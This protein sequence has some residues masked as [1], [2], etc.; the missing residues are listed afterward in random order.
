MKP[1]VTSSMDDVRLR[2]FIQKYK[3]QKISKDLLDE[4]ITMDFLMAQSEQQLD[5]IAME[6]TPRVIQQNKFKFGVKE[7]Q[8]R[9]T[10]KR[11]AASK[12]KK[13]V[14]TPDGLRPQ[15]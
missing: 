8:K 4:G 7:L 14:P 1:V 2:K 9:K 10:R 3:L 11:A 13:A 5:A 6:L 12:S 15:Q